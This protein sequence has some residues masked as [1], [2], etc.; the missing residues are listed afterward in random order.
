MFGKVGLYLQDNTEEFG[1]GIDV[2]VGSQKV[3]TRLS[4]PILNYLCTRLYLRL[5][6]INNRRK[7][8]APIKSAS[9]I[10]FDFRFENNIGEVS[11]G[12]RPDWIIEGGGTPPQDSVTWREKLSNLGNHKIPKIISREPPHYI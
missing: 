10:F 3:W 5:Y 11:E 2:V 6:K 4:I 9:A 8:K 7:I 12:I 1:G